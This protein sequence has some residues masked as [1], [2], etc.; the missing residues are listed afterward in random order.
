MFVHIDKIYIIESWESF[1]I[2]NGFS[3]TSLY[4]RQFHHYGSRI[5]TTEIRTSLRYLHGKPPWGFQS[6]T[7]IQQNEILQV[8]IHSSW[9]YLPPQALQK[10]L[11]PRHYGA[12]PVVSHSTVHLPYDWSDQACSSRSDTWI[13]LSDHTSVES[14]GCPRD[15]N[16]RTLALY[17]R[18]RERERGCNKFDGSKFLLLTEQIWW[19]K[20][21]FLSWP[22]I[23]IFD[24]SRVE[25]FFDLTNL[26]SQKS[27]SFL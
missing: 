4:G 8:P 27:N 12:C 1:V 22:N 18:E 16:H 3:C 13:L 24:G 21:L 26:M 25:L 6:Q 14:A 10:D 9:L 2:G 15:S 7:R 5:F 17:L 23:F 19:V 20:S 11:N